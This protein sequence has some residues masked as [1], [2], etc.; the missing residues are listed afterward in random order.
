LL[1]IFG[2]LSPRTV[3]SLEEIDSAVPS[4]DITKIKPRH[5]N[6]TMSGL[7]QA[8]D[9][10]VN[11]SGPI[12]VATTNRYEQLDEALIRPGR[13]NHHIKLD[14]SSKYQ[15][16][17][18]FKRYLT[19]V[20]DEYPFS[21]SEIEKKTL[22]F[23]ENLKN[24]NVSCASLTGYLRNAIN[25]NL[26]IDDIIE[27]AKSLKASNDVGDKINFESSVIDLFE[28]LKLR[29]EIIDFITTKLSIN[30]VREFKFFDLGEL[31]DA[32]SKEKKYNVPI[33]DKLLLQEITQIA[34]KMISEKLRIKFNSQIDSKF[35]ENFELPEELV[36]KI[37]NLGIK[38]IGN[39]KFATSELEKEESEDKEDNKEVNNEKK[40]RGRRKKR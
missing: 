18:I 30:T 32:I 40:R 23:S 31:Y 19:Y 11:K 37:K 4:R 9:G 25:S 10:P 28:R 22:Q 20:K 8:L 16:E 39:L 36:N 6:V 29:K 13:F 38:T 14:W 12:L 33:K 34:E 3:I 26:N 1:E 27:G 5:K 2:K 17:A 35:V 21:E 7:L 15:Q 24:K